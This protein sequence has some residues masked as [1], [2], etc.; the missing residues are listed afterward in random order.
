MENNVEKFPELDVKLD[1][2][3]DRIETAHQMCSGSFDMFKD[4]VEKMS[5]KYTKEY[6]DELAKK[7]Y[8]DDR[9]YPENFSNWYKHII[10][11]GKFDHAEI[12]SNQIFT[13]D[14]IKI[15]EETDNIDKVNWEAINNILKPTLD[16]MQNYKVY[17]IKNGC[18]SNKF[19]FDTCLATKAN[20]AEKLW[21]INYMSAMYSTGG[22]TELVVRELIPFDINEIPTIYNGMPLREE[23]R[24]FYNM[25]RKILEYMEDYWKYK[26]CRNHINNK[27]DQIVFDWFHNKLKTRQIQHREILKKLYERI[28]NDISTLKFDDE[29]SGIWSIDFMYVAETDK[30]YLIDM[31]R[32]FRSAYWNIDKLTYISQQEIIRERKQNGK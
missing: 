9:N 27:S 28:W 2:T 11:F 7:A 8:E 31:A 21:K 15:M 1:T 29:L 12:I 25:D 4:I 13:Y 26:Y 24:V 32:G 17:N 30:L 19:D 16:K 3:H 10:D 18:F 20:L 23:I 14:G 22:K 6:L 5:T